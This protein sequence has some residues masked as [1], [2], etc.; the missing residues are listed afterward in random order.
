MSTK[1]GGA[2]KGP[3]KHQNKRAYKPF[4]DVKKNPSEPGGSDGRTFAPIAGVC[5]RC[6][7][8]L[9]WRRKYGKYKPLSA[10]TKCNWCQKRNVRSAYHAICSACANA[11]GACGKCCKQVNHIVGKGA[12]QEEAER[13]N[14]E[15]ALSGMRERDR[16]TLLRAM[17]KGSAK[18]DRG[19]ADDAPTG[20][21]DVES[22]VD[23]DADSGNSGVESNDEN[24]VSVS[25]K[26]KGRAATTSRSADAPESKRANEENA[27]DG[28][29]PSDSAS[30]W[31]SEGEAEANGVGSDEKTDAR[32]EADD[33]SQEEVAEASR[34]SEGVE[35]LR[36][37]LKDS[38]AVDE[39]H[40]A[41]KAVSAGGA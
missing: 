41:G 10:P 33:I 9:E 6:K 29:D 27:S 26:S 34:G 15:E 8:Q 2:P 40:E 24:E 39:G 30:E 38:L 20:E 36:K 3:P 19:P 4:Q 23:S 14:L 28:D 18:L 37:T 16:R 5:V 11:K 1:R 31:E 21:E 7:E 22:D 35:M 12:E 17:E 32:R 13:R 25:R